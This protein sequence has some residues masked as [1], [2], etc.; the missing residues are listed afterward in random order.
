MARFDG[1]RCV[2]FNKLHEFFE[3]LS[4]ILAISLLIFFLTLSLGM[5]MVQI[6]V[7]VLGSG[8]AAFVTS[9]CQDVGPRTAQQK[10]QMYRS[11]ISGRIKLHG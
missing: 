4:V 3:E 9:N 6:L 5:I 10:W 8:R 2:G 7:L 11:V 1:N